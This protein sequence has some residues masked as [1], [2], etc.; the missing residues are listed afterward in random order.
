MGC[1]CGNNAKYDWIYVNST[2]KST[3]YN[4]EVEAKAA[5]VRDQHRGVIRQV[6]KK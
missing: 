2:G 5:K 4:S 3:T 6:P 1:N